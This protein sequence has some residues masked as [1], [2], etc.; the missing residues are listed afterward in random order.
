MIEHISKQFCVCIPIDDHNR[1]RC[2]TLTIDDGSILKTG[3]SLKN[4]I[5]RF[6]CDDNIVTV[7]MEVKLCLSVDYSTRFKRQCRCKPKVH[8]ILYRKFLF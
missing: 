8:C 2:P 5:S 6:E 4:D 7:E 1:D 3:I